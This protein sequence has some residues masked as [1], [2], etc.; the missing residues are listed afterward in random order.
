[1]RQAIENLDSVDFSKVRTEKPLF[2][3]PFLGLHLLGVLSTL[4]RLD[5]PIPSRRGQESINKYLAF[6][7]TLVATSSRLGPIP[8]LSNL[9]LMLPLMVISS[10][11][12]MIGTVPFMI[13]GLAS[14]LIYNVLWS[15]L[16]FA[17]SLAEALIPLALFPN[18]VDASCIVEL[19][20]CQYNAMLSNVF[21]ALIEATEL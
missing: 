9:W 13:G 20:E 7:E 5:P 21:P 18:F 16:Q 4:Q 8:D 14:A 6:T 10:V 2:M 17:I 1:M 15:V 11:P 3:N 12:L 19:V